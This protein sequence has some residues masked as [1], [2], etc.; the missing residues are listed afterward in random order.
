MKKTPIYKL[1]SLIDIN[2]KKNFS[3]F[4]M[5]I[6]WNKIHSIFFMQ[7]YQFRN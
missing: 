7:Y 5:K 2:F 3:F 6:E 4:K 1:E